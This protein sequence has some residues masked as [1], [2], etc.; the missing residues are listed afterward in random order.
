MA[1]AVE[2]NIAST[3]L[4]ELLA[5]ARDRFYASVLWWAD[6]E[7][8]T[9]PESAREVY[10]ALLSGPREAIELAVRLH[11]VMITEHANH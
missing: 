9:R 4:A 1:L 8:M 5:E 3:T 7:V 11:K 6:R 10:R 2:K